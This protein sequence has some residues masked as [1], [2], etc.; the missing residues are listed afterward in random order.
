MALVTGATTVLV[1][2]ITLILGKRLERRK[3][4]EAHF[5]EKKIGIYDEF[6]S[7]FFSIFYSVGAD[8]EVIPESDNMLE[9]LKKFQQKLLLWGG[10]ETLQEFIDWKAALERT[11][12]GAST[13]FATERFLRSLRKD[14]GL[15]NDKLKRG[16]FARLILRN[17][18]LLI[19]MKKVDPNVTL[20]DLAKLEKSLSPGEEG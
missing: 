11:P 16:A 7:E 13:I 6:L 18:E 20:D 9:F 5:R 4:I 14:I 17:S 2:T 3:E 8:D 1:A 15:S 12:P 10:D 19:Q